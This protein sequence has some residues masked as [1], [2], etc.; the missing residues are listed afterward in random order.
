MKVLGEQFLQQTC[1]MSVAVNGQYSSFAIWYRRSALKSG[2]GL[3]VLCT[4][5]KS[6]L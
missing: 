5:R 2:L 4:Q 3:Q 1:H 6:A